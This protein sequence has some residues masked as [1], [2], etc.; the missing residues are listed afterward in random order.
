VRFLSIEPL[1]G[2]LKDLDLHDIHWAIVGGESG[3]GARPM[4]Q[5]WVEEIQRQCNEQNVRFFF[6]QWGGTNKKASGRILHGRTYDEMPDLP[7]P[8]AAIQPSLEL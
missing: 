5:E 3:P 4:K 2:P 1:L 6:K 8:H 7:E